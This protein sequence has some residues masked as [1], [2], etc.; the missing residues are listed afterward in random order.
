LV[1][2][3]DVPFSSGGSD[4]DDRLSDELEYDALLLSLADTALNAST[5]FAMDKRIPTLFGLRRSFDDERV[6]LSLRLCAGV[7]ADLT[8]CM[9]GC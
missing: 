4:V 8:P 1:D 9:G 3:A 2:E 5:D 7:G 6:L